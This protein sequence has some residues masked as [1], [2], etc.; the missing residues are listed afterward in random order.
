M[1]IVIALGILAG[2][3]FIYFALKEIAY[4]NTHWR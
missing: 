1:K 4:R 3:V 2:A